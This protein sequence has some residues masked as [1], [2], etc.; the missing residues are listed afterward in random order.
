MPQKGS[1][2]LTH[3]QKNKAG[4]QNPQT[5]SSPTAA[6]SANALSNPQRWVFPCFS[7][8]KTGS[9]PTFLLPEA[10]LQV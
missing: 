4:T 7:M 9:G 10:P 8:G 1:P 3:Q 5:I 6:N 2:V